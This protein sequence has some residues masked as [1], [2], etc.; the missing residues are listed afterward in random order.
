MRLRTG[1][2][3]EQAGLLALNKTAHVALWAVCGRCVCWYSVLVQGM[4]IS[5]NSTM[6]FVETLTLKVLV[7]ILAD[8]VGRP[9][10]YEWEHSRG[11]QDMQLGSS[12][13]QMLLT[14][15]GRA[16]VSVEY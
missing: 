8:L 12:C 6:S 15:C 9:G 13:S 14:T 1:A 7:I 4:R 16:R 11:L 3:C 2:A 10:S 5:N